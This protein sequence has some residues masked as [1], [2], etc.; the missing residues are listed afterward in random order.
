MSKPECM[1][2]NKYSLNLLRA[3][4]QYVKPERDLAKWTG[5]P[6]FNFRIVRMGSLEL[7]Q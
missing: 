6:I 7:T 1:E 3:V 2:L 5:Q 4:R